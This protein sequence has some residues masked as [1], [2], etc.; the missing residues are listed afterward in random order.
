MGRGGS[1]FGG[2]SNANLPEP[3]HMAAKTFRTKPFLLATAGATVDG[4]TI[5][6]K[7]IKEMAS[8]YDPKTY[9]AR[10]NIEHIRGISGTAP[11]NSYGDIV[12]L[13]T[14]EVDVNMNGK[15]EKRL[16][17]FGTLDVY[18]NAKQLNDA[19][20]K[21]YPSIEIHPDFGGKGFA[22]CMG[23]ALTDSPAA[24]ATQRMQFN[25]TDPSRLNVSSD[26]AA[27]LEFVEEAE[28]ST[29][30]DSFFSRLGDLLKP[31][32]AKEAAATVGAPAAGTEAPAAAAAFDPAAFTALIAGVGQHFDASVAAIKL[33]SEKQAE[34]LEAKITALTAQIETTPANGFTARPVQTGFNNQAALTDC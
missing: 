14:A 4:R 2:N 17:L 34:L 16:G 25:R 21:V 5:D 24:I 20:Q 18:E 1:A 12:E 11:F 6:D 26:E 13:S 23:V 28:A 8:S 9:G 33:A 3:D 30:M 27:L 22:Y 10:V 29:G 7:M 32:S 19:G 15:T 31:F